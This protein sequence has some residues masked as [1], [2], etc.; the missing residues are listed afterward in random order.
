MFYFIKE[1]LGVTPD[2]DNRSNFIFS[3]FDSFS[4]ALQASSACFICS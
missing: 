1:A 2:S 3:L 4:S